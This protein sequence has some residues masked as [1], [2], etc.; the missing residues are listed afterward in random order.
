MMGPWCRACVITT[1]NPHA[2]ATYRLVSTR[3]SGPSLAY[4]SRLRRLALRRPGEQPA[5]VTLIPL[6]LSAPSRDPLS[7]QLGR[8]RPQAHPFLLPAM[9]LGEHGI[10]WRLHVARL[11]RFRLTL[12][13]AQ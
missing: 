2:P 11:E 4:L 9:D 7:V 12:H 13:A 8:D 1:R 6:A 5:Q 10:L 3:R